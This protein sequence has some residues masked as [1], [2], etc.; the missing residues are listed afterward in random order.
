M[1]K[2]SESII[3]YSKRK[4]QSLQGDTDERYNSGEEEPN[5]GDKDVV[6]SV[7]NYT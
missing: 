5:D 3:K 2:E 1:R 7:G 4:L 6:V